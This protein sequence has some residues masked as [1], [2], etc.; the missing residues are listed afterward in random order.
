MPFMWS[1]IFAVFSRG[2][3][4]SL[5]HGFF[6]CGAAFFCTS[7]VVGMISPLDLFVVP[8]PLGL[9]SSSQFKWWLALTWVSV[10]SHWHG[11]ED[12]YYY[13]VC[14]CGIEQ[15]LKV[16]F[17]SKSTFIYIYV[18]QLLSL[19]ANMSVKYSVLHQGVRSHL[20]ICT[21]I[22]HLYY[23]SLY[24]TYFSSYVIIFETSAS[25]AWTLNS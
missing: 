9:L 24:I 21:Y 14:A 2:G 12:Y 3:G 25:A 22:I 16:S 7:C 10:C 6:V 8:L 11:T 23:T 15:H 19:H 18:C 4:K 5:L 17:S 20:D 1:F 13:R